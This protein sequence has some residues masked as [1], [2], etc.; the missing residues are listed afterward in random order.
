MLE[1]KAL[2]C[3]GDKFGVTGSVGVNVI[4]HI[5]VAK[6]FAAHL[7]ATLPGQIQHRKTVQRRHLANGVCIIN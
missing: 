6:R 1:D 7:H 3:R 2:Q 5:G 4:C